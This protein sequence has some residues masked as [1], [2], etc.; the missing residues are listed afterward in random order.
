LRE[1][2]KG[3]WKDGDWFY[4]SY[5]RKK[6]INEWILSPYCV[7]SGYYGASLHEGEDT[8]PK[9]NALPLLSIGQCI[10]LLQDKVAYFSMTNMFAC[11]D[12]VKIAWGIS[13]PKMFDIRAEEL[14][15]CLWQAVKEVL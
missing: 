11:T 12:G 15:D 2:W 13:K 4:G 6:E 1:W 7:D 10:E 5:G 14:C 3:N 8:I 9:D